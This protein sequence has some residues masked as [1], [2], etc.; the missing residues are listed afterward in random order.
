MVPQLGFV[1]PV[2]IN[3]IYA[4]D[5]TTKVGEYITYLLGRKVYMNFTADATQ[6]QVYNVIS[7]LT[8]YVSGS[9]ENDSVEGRFGS[10]EIVHIKNNG[11]SNIDLYNNNNDIFK[12]FI[13]GNTT[14]IG[15]TM[16]IDMC[17]MI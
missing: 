11:D 2:S 7:A 10:V 15:F 14:A 17:I 6:E 5:G 1:D 12:T 3:Y 13:S 9:Y 4:S 16:Q 8:S